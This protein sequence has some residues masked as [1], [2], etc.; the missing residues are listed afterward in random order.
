[1]STPRTRRAIAKRARDTDD[2]FRPRFHHPCDR[3]DVRALVLALTALEKLK[4]DDGLRERAYLACR[5]ELWAGLAAALAA[6]SND[7]FSEHRITQDPRVARRELLAARP[8]VR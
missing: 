5:R 1:M 7:Y 2:E 3:E 4:R 8:P 6:S